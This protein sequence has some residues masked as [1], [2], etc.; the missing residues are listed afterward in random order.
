MCTVTLVPLSE[1]D[2]VLISNRDEAPDRNSLPPDFY[3]HNDLELLYPKDEQSEG[4]WIGMSEK[5]RLICLLN[6]GFEIHQRQ[7]EY[8]MSRGLVVKDLLTSNTLTLDV[9]AY[10]LTG[11][12]PFTMV[13]VEWDDRLKFYEL[14]WDGSKKHFQEL[15]LMPRIWSS[16]TLYNKAMRAERQQ[17]F[18]DFK[19]ENQLNPYSLFIF[20][21]TAGKGNKDYGVIMDRGFVKTTSITRIEKEA[22]TVSMRYHDIDSQTHYT[23]FLN[24]TSQPHE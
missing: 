5:K 24:E 10:D 23:K 16:S 8:R 14:V 15:P 20:H 2:F 4:S 7:P 13:I 21:Q 3:E 12:E 1:T 17:W 19:K 9:E 22:D 6:G 11:I 18:E